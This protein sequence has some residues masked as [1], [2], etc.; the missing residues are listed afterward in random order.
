MAISPGNGPNCVSRHVNLVSLVR[1]ELFDADRAMIQASR[2]SQDMVLCSAPHLAWF[3]LIESS[4][5]Q[6]IPQ[7]KG[8]SEGIRQTERRAS[9][10]VTLTS[11]LVGCYREFAIQRSVAVKLDEAW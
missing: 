5:K 10:E 1:M 4:G 8:G 3:P 7:W 6:A 9:L 2:K 11:C